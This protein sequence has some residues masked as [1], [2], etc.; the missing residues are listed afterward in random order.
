MRITLRAA[1]LVGALAGTGLMSMEAAQA[2]EKAKA[3]AVPVAAK[4]KAPAGAGKA[5]VDPVVQKAVAKP[6]V[7]KG[8]AGPQARQQAKTVSLARQTS[9]APLAHK[10]TPAQGNG[11]YSHVVHK[12][13][14]HRVFA[15]NADLWQEPS[16]LA[17]HSGS[18]LVIAQDGGEP[19]YEK[20]ANAVVPIASITKV[21]TAMVVLDSLPNLQ[22]PI[23]ISDE[24]VDYL[25]GSR[26]RLQVGTVI[27]RET[28]LL[29]AL[30]SSENRA[31]N[32]LGRHYPGGLQAFVAAM[33]RK[34]ASL[35]MSSSHFEDPTGLN[36]NNVSTAHDLARMV[37]A[38]H[39]YPLIREFSTTSGAR[40][41]VK[42]RELE[43]HNTNQLVSSP[44]WEIGLSKT[45]YIQEAGK[46]LVMQA[47][48]A[49]KPV[50][51]VLLDSAGK[52]TRIGDAIRIKRWMESASASGRLP[53]RV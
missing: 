12:K 43:F 35:G 34:A 5:K 37:A 7:A 26:S 21:M 8:K 39:R 50:V 10:A 11:G 46:C 49:E 2:V 41:E 17:V 30:M 31:A 20:N 25:R 18:A 19:L 14:V 42:G 28:A 48:V 1:V 4:G 52:Q 29:L 13:G 45:G 44:T 3:K 6:V 33:N 24:D 47:R 15:G 40:A 36:S 23:T 38:A 9:A 27:P 53:T 32:A 51:I 22:A 16:Q